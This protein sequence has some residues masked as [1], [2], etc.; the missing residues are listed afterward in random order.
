VT[1]WIL[2][3]TNAWSPVVLRAAFWI[4]SESRVAGSWLSLI[5]F[6]SWPITGA[7]EVAFSGENPKS[8]SRLYST[9]PGLTGPVTKA[10]GTRSTPVNDESAPSM[11]RG[12]VI[13]W[14]GNA[15]TSRTGMSLAALRLAT[16]VACENGGGQT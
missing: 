2:V 10:A 4:W 9:A 5:S 3:V 7:G 15:S 8:P 14:G 11:A 6:T 12:A 16:H 13:G 1:A